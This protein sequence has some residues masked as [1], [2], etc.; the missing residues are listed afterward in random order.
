MS[1]QPIRNSQDPSEATIDLT[2][3]SDGSVTSGSP[4]R[5]PAPRRTT[6]VRAA[7]FGNAHAVSL[8]GTSR[9]RPRQ[10]QAAQQ[11]QH[12]PSPSLAPLGREQD[13]PI[14]LLSDDSAEEDED[15]DLGDDAGSVASAHT[16]SSSPDIQI[17][18]ERIAPGAI[19]RANLFPRN[20]RFIPETPGGPP[21]TF[22]YFPDILRQ[23]TEFMFRN[24]QNAY[25]DVL[26]NQF[27]ML[28][29]RG[30]ER[31]ADRDVPG[32]DAAHEI[33]INLDYRQPGFA[34]GGL[35]M[36]DRS[37]ETPQIVQEP[38][39]GPGAAREGFV[40]TFA[41]D[42]VCLCPRCGDELA[43]GKGDLKQQVWVAKQCGHV[44]IT[45]FFSLHAT[46]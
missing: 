37:S 35:E 24:V 20:R 38:Y 27:D 13:S 6:R 28:R 9:R 25:N 32:H 11:E 17:V 23:G 30:G 31:R 39:K 34:L 18:D 33:T 10:P 19:R 14:V 21:E 46:C 15:E 44:S 12:R 45:I 43:T 40:R 7:E 2:V 29:A 42:D 41:E 4:P 5:R 26:S 36:F 8:T 22:G 16:L 1:T 3:D